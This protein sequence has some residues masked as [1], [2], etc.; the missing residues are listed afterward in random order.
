MHRPRLCPTWAA[1]ILLCWGC[2]SCG[3][4][5]TQIIVVIGTDLEVPQELTRVEVKVTNVNTGGEAENVAFPAG[6][7]TSTTP[8]PRS[9]VIGPHGDQTDVV[10]VLKLEAFGPMAANS[11]KLF[12][13]VIQTHFITEKTLL[14]PVF[15]S[16]ACLNF[17]CASSKTCDR[18][19]CIAKPIAP[20]DLDEV[21]AGAEKNYDFTKLPGP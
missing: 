12:D 6:T 19:K 1:W 2:V 7:E 8:F 18:G 10:L 13:R 3:S 15:L 17:P 20:Q 9:F 21:R 5:P 14:L 16:S 11:G 4:E